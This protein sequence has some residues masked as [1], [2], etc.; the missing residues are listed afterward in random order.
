MIGAS[1]AGAYRAL[2]RHKLLVAAI[3]L[4]LLGG[5]PAVAYADDGTSNKPVTKPDDPGI[6][7]LH[8]AI[9]DFRQ[10]TQALRERCRDKTTRQA[11]KAELRRLHDSFK[12][13]RK[14]AMDEHRAFVEKRKHDELKKDNDKKADGKNTRKHERPKPPKPPKP[15]ATPGD[16]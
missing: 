12:D 9:Q 3:A 2:V 5:L 8:Q 16:H 13:A 14:K 11:C 15:E 6:A 4:G 1:I 10:E 7:A